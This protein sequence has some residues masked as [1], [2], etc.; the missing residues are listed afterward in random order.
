M[1]EKNSLSEKIGKLT[2]NVDNLDK[3]TTEL[4]IV[5]DKLVELFAV[6]RSNNEKLAVIEKK[7]DELPETT[8]LITIDVAEQFGMNYSERNEIR[9]DLLFLRSLRETTEDTKR[10]IFRDIAKKI[11]EWF[12]VGVIASQGI[13]K[14]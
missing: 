6:Y 13:G 12:I 3:K 1:T 4:T 8:K 7:I 10:H 14:L 5:V 2:A 11:V 9:K